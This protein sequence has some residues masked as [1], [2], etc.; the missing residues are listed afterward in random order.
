MSA[1]PT[2]L[3]P[4][5]LECDVLATDGATVHVRAIRPDDGDLLVEFHGRL[6][7]ETVYRRF[8]GAH[9]RLSAAEV[10]YLTHV[11]YHDRL[12]LVAEHAD[13]LIAVA[14]YER[15]PASGDAEVAFVV[16]D[17]DQG[18][19]LGT[20]LL[21]HL[22][23]A[24]R[25]RGVTRFVAD[26]QASNTAM[27]DVFGQAGFSVERTYDQGIVRLE[28]PIEPTEAFVLAVEDR[29]H[30]AEGRSIESLL[31][32]ASI[33]VVGVSAKSGG[34]GHA[35]FTNIVDGGYTGT[36]HPV[37]RRGEPV[38]GHAGFACL[39]EVPGPVELVVVAVGP[40]DTV[41]LVADAARLGARGL[42]VISAGFAE[43][44]PDGAVLQ[45]RLVDAAR[46]Q[47]MR[48]VGP[49]CLG[50]ANTAPAVALNA[51]FSP[52]A[53]VAGPTGLL[54]QSGAVGIVALEQAA[55]IGLGI[56]SFV[57]VGNTADVSGN[58]LLEYWQDDPATEV[59][60]LYLESVGNPR[61]FARLAGACRGPNRSWRSRAGAATPGAGRPPRIP[62]PRRAPTW[63]STPSSPGPALSGSTP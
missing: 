54:S 5:E 3:A 27:L 26:T 48:V 30:R 1:S 19:G 62:R 4:S 9:P 28:F 60:C 8:F 7:P 43:A 44:G 47:G 11:D 42:V 17:A 45:R 59:I 49:N 2:A 33:A 39:A 12:A 38:A 20:L 57:S 50:V 46:R 31:R 10:E 14:R 22:A 56:S 25:A 16:D 36:A 52:A 41:D 55:R 35:I 21:E 15:L 63:R 6:S 58:D 32:P 29:G 24:A 51:T 40:E 13:R 61:R 34:I 18:R 53:P 37:N 23:A